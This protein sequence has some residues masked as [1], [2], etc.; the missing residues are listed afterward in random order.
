MALTIAPAEIEID[1]HRAAGREA[2][3]WLVRPDLGD[4]GAFETQRSRH[5]ASGDAVTVGRSGGKDGNIGPTHLLQP[6]SGHRRA[7]AVIVDQ[8][9][10]P[11]PSRDARVGFLHQLA[12]GS[13]AGAAQMPGLVF[14]GGADVEHVEGALRASARHRSSVALSVRGM[15]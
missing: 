11:T 1:H 15:S 13:R 5:V 10:P 3:A 12:P 4:H 6:G 8:H 9:D 14:F 2:A 7:H